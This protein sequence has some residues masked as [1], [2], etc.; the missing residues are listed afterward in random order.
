MENYNTSILLVYNKKMEQSTKQKSRSRIVLFN[1]GLPPPKR[2]KIRDPP[3]KCYL[4]NS[5]SF[6]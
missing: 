2:V 6:H 5:V 1:N 4:V 3:A